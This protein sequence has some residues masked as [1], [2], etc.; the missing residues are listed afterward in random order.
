MKK[1]KKNLVA[2][3]V[4][5]MLATLLAGCGSSDDNKSNSSDTISNENATTDEDSKTID[6][7][8]DGPVLGITCR[9]TTN[10][11]YKKQFDVMQEKCNEYGIE[12]IVQDAREDLATQISQIENF[13]AME[14]DYIYV[15]VFDADGIK[16]TIDKA[17]DAG[18]F[19]IV[20]DAT[21]EN[22]SLTYGYVDNYE[23][24]YQIGEMAAKF[25][26]SNDE[27]KDAEVVEWG[28]QT[29]TVVSDII[30]RGEGVKDAIAENAPNAKLVIEQDVLSTEEGVTTT[31]N[32]IQAHPDIKIVCGIT[33]PFAYGSYQ[34]FQAVGY[35]GDE[36][37]IFACDGTDQALELISDN[38]IFRGTVAL[39]L[40][41]G[42]REL[43]DVLWDKWNGEEIS[44]KVA[45]EMV[46]VTSENIV[47]YLE[48]NE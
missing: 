15:N 7:N 20:H 4:L 33:D 37:G 6:G 8:K 26:N 45:F 25:I 23:Y 21:F 34:A 22:A 19:V 10:Q 16:D 29:Y 11:T 35:T 9:D 39:P 38:T 32:F 46:Q 41:E 30:A 17:V 43:I 13:M 5:G 12:M 18:F 28:L 42:A 44:D 27:L 3:L 31:E 36:Y 47:Q 2:I 1:L 48:E 24:G 14:V 40:E